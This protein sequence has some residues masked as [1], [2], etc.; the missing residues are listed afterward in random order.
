M[1]TGKLRVG[2]IGAGSYATG[3]NIPNL[4]KTG[5]VEI[6][7]ISR[8]NP[9]RLARIQETLQVG[10]A[11]TDWRQMLD[12]VDLDAVVVSTSHDAHA[13]PTLAALA[14]G[15]HVLVEKPMALRSQ[16]ARAM[17]E[18]AKKAGRV[19]MVGSN[20]RCNGI[21][22][23]AK[24]RLAEGAIGAVRQIDMAMATNT[25]WVWATDEHAAPPSLLAG[26]SSTEAG[27][28]MVDDWRQ[29]KFWRSQPDQMGGGMFIDIG[30]HA[31]DV[32]L[33]L[34]GGTPKRVAAFQESA[35]L[36]VEAFTSVQT[37]L[38]N[39]VVASFAFGASVMGQLDGFWGYGRM[40]IFAD[41]GTMTAEWEGWSLLGSRVW[42]DSG[43]GPQRLE[44][45]I[46][47]TS[48]AEAFVTTV[49][50]GAPN[51]A[52]G[53]TGLDVVALAEATYRSAAE[54]RIV[55]LA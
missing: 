42:L 38:S 45:A 26:L 1:S 50:D 43:Q 35:G 22:Q 30:A 20:E 5:R 9:E 31:I 48:P 44:S 4:R 16:D 53:Q 18:A 29:G 15:L 47:D 24:R 7:A 33:W 3:E 55:S 11:F 49:L 6:A 17:I 14:Q 41:R 39:G 27:K 46:P 36:P 28:F 52:S 32:M 34:A 21:W 37:Q 13:E 54:G 2:I 8:R 51:L 23:M 40:V 10:C 12:Q 25:G 19:L